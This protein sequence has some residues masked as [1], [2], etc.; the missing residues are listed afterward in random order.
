GEESRPRKTDIT[1]GCSIAKATPLIL[2]TWKLYLAEERISRNEAKQTSLRGISPLSGSGGIEAEAFRP[3]TKL[4][5]QPSLRVTRSSAR[6]RSLPNRRLYGVGSR[7]QS[8]G[9]GIGDASARGTARV[10][11][12][13]AQTPPRV[14]TAASAPSPGRGIGELNPVPPSK[15]R[16]RKDR[17]RE[18]PRS[19]ER[20]KGGGSKEGSSQALA[21]SSTRSA[22]AHEGTDVRFSSPGIVE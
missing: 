21:E 19:E 8:T 15:L 20:R 3:R 5:V 17:S 18:Y 1:S 22:R 10:R 11:G 16:G 4:N 13:G 7:L 14:R 2:S 9:L 6:S 12:R